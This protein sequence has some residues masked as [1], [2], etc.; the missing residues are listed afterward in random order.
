MLDFDEKSLD[1]FD[2]VLKA[3]QKNGLNKHL[4]FV[5]TSNLLI[6]T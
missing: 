6:V 3:C 4:R 5:I 2:P 1:L